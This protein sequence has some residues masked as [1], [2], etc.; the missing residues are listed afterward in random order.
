MADVG[1]PVDFI[2]TQDITITNQT[3]SL[4][5]KQA[6]NLRTF[7][8]GDLTRRQRTDSVFEN[9]WDLRHIAYEADIMV[10]QP[11]IAALVTLTVQTNN[12][13]PIKSWAITMS[14]EGGTSTTITLNAQLAK[15]EFIDEGI[16]AMKYNIRLEGADTTLGVV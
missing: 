1:V 16:G 14:D 6:T 5:Y 10:T 8:K 3:D 12:Q 9:L 7:I 4:T 11:E 13:L 15:L 2:D